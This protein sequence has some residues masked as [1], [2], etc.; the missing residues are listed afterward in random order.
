MDRVGYVPQI[1]TCITHMEVS[2]TSRLEVFGPRGC[3][4]S[5]DQM[6]MLRGVT[7]ID[8]FCLLTGICG[9]GC[10]PCLGIVCFSVVEEF[11]MFCD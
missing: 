4:T 1:E 6:V 3:I 7:L 9:R 2:S 10:E 5:F 8:D 11:V